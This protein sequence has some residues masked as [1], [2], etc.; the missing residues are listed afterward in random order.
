MSEHNT[1]GRNATVKKPPCKVKNHL[2]FLRVP[3]YLLQRGAASSRPLDKDEFIST[4]G[5]IIGEYESFRNPD[6]LFHQPHPMVKAATLFNEM[7]KYPK[8]FPVFPRSVWNDHQNSLI[9]KLEKKRED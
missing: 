1:F 3:P 2:H 8:A 5:R 7:D 6:E 9:K 4:L